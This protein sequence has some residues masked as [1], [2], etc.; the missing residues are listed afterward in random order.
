MLFHSKNVLLL[1][2]VW[3]GTE[4]TW[5]HSFKRRVYYFVLKATRVFSV[6]IHR[7]SHRSCSVKNVFLQILQNSQEN[8]TARDSFLIKLQ[9][10]WHR[11]FSVN[12]AKFLRTPFLNHTS[13]RLL[14]HTGRVDR[15]LNTLLMVNINP[16]CK[17]SFRE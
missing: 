17:R 4:Y 10:C 8:T 1:P 15:N 11:C 13:G 6:P 5:T 12:F 7:S 2:L 3:P 9:A 14:L 16:I